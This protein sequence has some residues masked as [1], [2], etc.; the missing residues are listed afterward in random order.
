MNIFV[1]IY[2]I[3]LYVT[4]L[5]KAQS[6]YRYE[7]DGNIDE[8]ETVYTGK[9][10]KYLNITEILEN[11]KGDKEENH[12]ETEEISTSASTT[13][14]FNE[15]FYN[16]LNNNNGEKDIYQY[17]YEQCN[18]L[19]PE[20]FFNITI[21]YYINKSK[22]NV[23]KIM[24]CLVYDNPNFWW[25]EKYDIIIK[26]DF[27]KNEE[28]YDI[29]TLLTVNF[30][31]E[32]SF[33]QNLTN[34]QVHKMNE[35]ISLEIDILLYQIE[36]LELHTKYEVLKFIHDYLI[37]N[38]I[39]EDDGQPFVQTLY[40]PLVNHKSVCSGY[41]EALRYIAS[42]FGINVIIA[43]SLTHEW[44]YALVN[45]KW[46]IIDVT[47]DDPVV[48]NNDGFYRPVK[49]DYS[50]LSHNYFLVGSNVFRGNTNALKEHELIYSYFTLKNLVVY[51]NIEKENY[52]HRPENDEY[53]EILKNESEIIDPSLNSTTT[54]AEIE[55]SGIK[56]YYY[57]YYPKMT[58]SLLRNIFI[59]IIL[60][61][62]L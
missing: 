44:N 32:N 54:T 33:F 15:K 38:T 62:L 18:R 42:F 58:F 7:F 13:I 53:V 11:G 50:N 55:N 20:L 49:G 21:P 59:F 23:E 12:Q 39:F 51:P 31:P 8:K 17:I 19:D 4:F 46:Y 30:T 27:N 25:I 43:R 56:Y 45:D 9:I 47:W 2:F 28:N 52:D 61:I 24:T 37:R 41:S 3:A 35:E 40:G 36:L 10:I 5:I 16:Q 60:I 1:L 48:S 26:N 57:Y 14:K 6:V 29:S 34:E 22:V